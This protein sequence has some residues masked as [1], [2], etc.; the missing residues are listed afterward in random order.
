MPITLNTKSIVL[1]IRICE[2]IKD[3]VDLSD[4]NIAQEIKGLL[5]EVDQVKDEINVYCDLMK[6]MFLS[7]SAVN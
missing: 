7:R 6:Q 5:N 2:M 1:L 3:L 4:D